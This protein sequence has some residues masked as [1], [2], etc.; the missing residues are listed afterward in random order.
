M[1]GI[2][3]DRDAIDYGDVKPGDSSAVET[4]L[5]TNIGTLDCDVTLEV[6]GVDSIAQSFYEQSLYID[7]SIYDIEAV[8]ASIIVAGSEDVDTQLQ[9]PISWAEGTGVQEATFIFWA[10]A[11]S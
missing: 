8:I 3:L 9:V 1:V 4:V 7:S 2:E 10:T 6:V 5:V 11:S